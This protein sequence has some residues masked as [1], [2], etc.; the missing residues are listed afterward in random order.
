MTTFLGRWR[1]LD[2]APRGKRPNIFNWTSWDDLIVYRDE[3]DEL[4]RLGTIT[5][6]LYRKRVRRWCKRYRELLEHRHWMDEL[7][8]LRAEQQTKETNRMKTD[9]P[10]TP[11]QNLPPLE[12]SGEPDLPERGPIAENPQPAA[13]ASPRERL[14]TSVSAADVAAESRNRGNG[15]Y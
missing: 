5:Y 15:G 4:R 13:T 11:E 10:N 1:T 7:S 14:P 8:R 3:Q 6:T 9:L 12:Y 2:G